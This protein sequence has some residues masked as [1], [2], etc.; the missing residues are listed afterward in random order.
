MLGNFVLLYI[1]FKIFLVS[2]WRLLFF[3]TYFYLTFN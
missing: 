2:W 1:H 3:L